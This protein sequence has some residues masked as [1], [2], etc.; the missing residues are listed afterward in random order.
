MLICRDLTQI[1]QNLR[2][3]EE[4]KVLNLVQSCCAHE[5]LTPLRC[6][7]QL[8]TKMRDSDETLKQDKHTL[9]VIG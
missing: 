1:K 4:I 8:T 5:M 2:L 6:I 7:D 3:H 9:K